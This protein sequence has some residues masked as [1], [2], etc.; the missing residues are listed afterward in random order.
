[1][2]V[3]SGLV[4]G[5]AFLDRQDGNGATPLHQAAHIS[6]AT[7]SIIFLQACAGPNI[8]DHGCGM[9]PLHAAA[10]TG[11]EEGVVPNLL[12]A[13]ADFKLLMSTG[14]PPIHAAGLSKRDNA[15]S[16]LLNV[17]AFKEHRGNSYG[18]TLLLRACEGCL[19]HT[20]RLLVEAEADV[21]SR[22][23]A[24]LTPLHG[25]CRFIDAESVETLLHAAAN[26][27]AVDQVAAKDAVEK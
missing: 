17:G 5:S 6:H 1:M 20:V 18:Q 9:S 2:A 26:S 16:F 19:P 7:T 12:E 8:G 4:K 11:C 15:V 23:T 3:V 27:S 13:G 24:G 21:E 22:S 10:G 14:H 25:A